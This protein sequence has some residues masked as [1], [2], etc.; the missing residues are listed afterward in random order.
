MA[1]PDG[2]GEDDLQKATGMFELLWPA[3]GNFLP[4]DISK[5]FMR[6]VGRLDGPAVQSE[7]TQKRRDRLMLTYQG[8]LAA[9][10]HGD[11][12]ASIETDVIQRVRA[13]PVKEMLPRGGTASTRMPVLGHEFVAYLLAAR[14]TL[15]YLARGVGSCFNQSSVYKIT[16]LGSAVAH[17]PPRDLG[18][19]VAKETEDVIARFPHLLSEADGRLSDRDRV[20]HYWPIEPAYLLIVHFPDGGI[21]LELQDGG[22]NYL[23]TYQDLDLERMSHDEHPLTAAVE[24]QLDQLT[25]FCIRLIAI[26][27]D[28]ALEL[29]R[30]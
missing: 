10:Y 20:A 30:P 21:G 6:E 5:A 2:I 22:H 8:L 4:V 17:M 27:V 28:A 29:R 11:R 24:S 3:V 16:K 15:D 19:R 12:I 7:Q 9:Y 26:A 14:R 1:D 18:A 13:A 25:A 23:P